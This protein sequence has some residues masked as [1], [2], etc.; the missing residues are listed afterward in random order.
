MYSIFCKNIFNPVLICIQFNVEIYIQFNV[1][2]CIQSDVE[3]YSIARQ[4]IFNRRSK[5][6]QSNDQYILSPW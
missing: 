2:K 3:I 6:I 4:N 1:E 5:Y